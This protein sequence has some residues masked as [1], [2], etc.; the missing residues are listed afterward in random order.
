M[1]SFTSSNLFVKPTDPQLE[2]SIRS[3]KK[4]VFWGQR[5]LL[6]SE[7]YFLTIFYLG[8]VWNI[9]PI[10]IYAGAA[11]G[12]HIELLKVLFPGLEFELYDPRRF[13]VK[14]DERTRIHQEFFTDMTAQYWGKQSRPI[15]FICDI[16]TADWQQNRNDEETEEQILG[17]MRT[18]E[19]WH[20]IM[21]PFASF[22]KFRLPWSGKGQ[23]LEVPYIDGTIVK[24][25]WARLSST[26]TRIIP[27]NWHR[28]SDDSQIVHR[29]LWD[30]LTYE[31]QLFYHNTVI[32]ET[33]FWSEGN[34]NPPEL[35]GSYD[36]TAE[37]FI[38]KMYLAQ[39]VIHISDTIVLNLSNWMSQQM[40]GTIQRHYQERK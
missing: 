19:R 12:G 9:Q 30:A 37:V 6:L 14:A 16:R 32:R 26:E 40:G 7:I 11:G 20:I 5:K 29:K 25:E 35:T 17:D 22:M 33:A 39:K 3:I 27:L 34:I 15:L 36:S 31:E 8:R 38:L 2:Y 4:G 28:R 1:Q 13:D 21:N 18:Q 10:V 24:Q 23:R